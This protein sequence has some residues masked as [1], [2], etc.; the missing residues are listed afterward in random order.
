MI[1]G[2]SV[3]DSFDQAL[4]SPAVFRPVALTAVVMLACTFAFEGTKQALFPGITIWQSHAVTIA[5]V[6]SVATAL[7]YVIA[8]RAHALQRALVSAQT[9]LE[10]RVRDRTQE[11]VARNEA[12]QREIAERTRAEEALRVSERNLAEAERVA[13]LGHWVWTADGDVWRS[14]GVR[15]L[16]D[17]DEH[18][19]VTLE[20][21]FDTAVHADDRA[22]ANEALE[23]ARSGRRIDLEYRL[24]IGAADP[25]HVRITAEPQIGAGGTAVRLRGTI[26][27]ISDR[28]RADAEN[29]RLEMQLRQ[30]QKMEAIGRLAGGIA[31]DFNNI[32]MVVIGQTELA[33]LQAHDMSLREDLQSVLDAA[34]RAASLTGQLL[35]FSRQ[36]VFASS[37]VDVN[38][39]AHSLED[40]LRRTIGE[41]IDLRVHLDRGEAPVRGDGSQIEQIILNLVVNARDAMPNGGRLTIEVAN[42]SFADASMT[43][44]GMRPPGAYVR[45][46]VTDT[47]HGIDRTVQERIFEPFFT[48]KAPG[49]GTGLGL[50]TVYGI[51]T[52]HEGYIDVYSEVNMGTAFKVYLP[53]ASADAVSPSAPESAPELTHGSETILLV[54]DEDEVRRL[55]REALRKQGYSV[56]EA[57]NGREALLFSDR[58]SSAIDLLLSDVVMPEMNGVEL[59]AAIRRRR[60]ETRVLFMSGYSERAVADHTVIE[61]T[62]LLQKPFSPVVALAAIRRLLDERHSSSV[63]P[64]RA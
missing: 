15:R 59:A 36:R 43:R 17:V 60:P 34:R 42:V 16:L 61:G 29:E 38:R 41:D 46:A 28:A 14:A 35:T 25:K 2:R 51:V 4:R 56:I 48:T 33:L 21:L 9:A 10:E 52:Q 31:H 6:S 18:A 24:H 3:S 57:R 62:E 23:T 58:F 32:L 40:M 13:H 22:R 5:V 64:V 11:L 1:E 19:P 50:S 45:I 47:G 54:E 27:D 39:L 20:Y 63:P 12:L 37:V 26:Q 55:L 30:A 8:R 49:K 53:L 7:S 44:A